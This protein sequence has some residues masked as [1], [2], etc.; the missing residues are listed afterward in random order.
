MTSYDWPTIRETAVQRLGDTPPAEVEQRILDVFKHSP[1]LVAAAID[2]TAK[3]AAGGNVRYP[4]SLVARMSEQATSP[5]AQLRVV[6]G[7]DRERAVAV[8]VRW[9]TNAGC[10]FDS[11]AEVE[12]ALFV[13]GFGDKGLSLRPW[14]HD[15]GLRAEMRTAWERVRPAG[16][17]VEAE[18]LERARTYIA[19]RA[20]MAGG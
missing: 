18:A 9:L 15:D 8:A 16:E 13:A 12:D 19:D 4:W 20:R 3:Q 6:D 7:T 5:V 17:R 14:A 1:Q 10:H 11:W 2:R